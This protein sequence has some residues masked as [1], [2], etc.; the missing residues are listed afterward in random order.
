M[1][2][3]SHTGRVDVFPTFPDDRIYNIVKSYKETNISS[4]P[5]K[6]NTK[7]Y[8]LIQC[9]KDN[10]QPKN[11]CFDFIVFRVRHHPTIDEPVI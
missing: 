10:K 2:G 11:I 6:K 8:M 7:H 1:R 3:C 9:A 5:Q 4:P